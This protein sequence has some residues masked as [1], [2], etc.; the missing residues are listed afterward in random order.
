MN[1]MD[2]DVSLLDNPYR[3]NAAD[4]NYINFSGI[5]TSKTIRQTIEDRHKI[6]ESNFGGSDLSMAS[7]L[8]DSIKSNV[9]G[10]PIKPT[11]INVSA[12]LQNTNQTPAVKPTS[13]SVQTVSPVNVPIEPRYVNA[14]VAASNP[15]P[16]V[17]ILDT[18]V[19]P[20]TVQEVKTAVE[21]ATNAASTTST[22]TN[23]STAPIVLSGGGGGGGSAPAPEENVENSARVAEEKKYFGLTKK[24]G[25][26]ALGVI[27][28]GTLAYFKFVKKA[29]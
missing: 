24:Q 3:F 5:N 22:S 12:L 13:T 8:D 4:K 2:I 26:I 20:T 11:S 29:F 6:F 7:M 14:T 17:A 19:K 18:S 21:A 9:S 15:T 23:S 27:A 28:V 1:Q 25:L 10:S 16:K